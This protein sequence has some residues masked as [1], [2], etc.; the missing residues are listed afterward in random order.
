M[1]K[2]LVRLGVLYTDRLHRCLPYSSWTTSNTTINGL[3]KGASFCLFRI[4]ISLEATWSTMAPKTAPTVGL[5]VDLITS[6]TVA[7]FLIASLPAFKNV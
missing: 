3:G 2:N 5:S 4:S 6:L 7:P 1:D